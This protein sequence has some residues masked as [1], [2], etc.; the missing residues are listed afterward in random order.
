MEIPVIIEDVVGNHIGR[1]FSYD[2]FLTPFYGLS[3]NFHLLPFIIKKE[4]FRFDIYAT[5]KIA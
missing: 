5:G 2:L 1:Q 3:I 4:D